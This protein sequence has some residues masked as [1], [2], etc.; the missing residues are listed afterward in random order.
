MGLQEELGEDPPDD[1]TPESFQRQ[2][3]YMS[4]VLARHPP[5]EPVIFDRCPLDFVAYMRAVDELDLGE[6]DWSMSQAVLRSVEA[7]LRSLD[8]IVLVRPDDAGYG[9]SDDG[10]DL[11]RLVDRYLVEL[12]VDDVLGLMRGGDG[13]SVQE[14]EGSTG[15]RVVELSRLAR[16]PGRTAPAR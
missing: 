1:L 13:P 3:E 5:G 4:D 2:L 8:L 15:K 9:E 10:R 7:G 6:S 11:K 12:L 16:V 14:L